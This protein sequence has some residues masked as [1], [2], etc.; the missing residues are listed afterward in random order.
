MDEVIW[1]AIIQNDAAYND[2]FFYGVKSTGIFCRPSCRSRNPK[3]ENVVI[4][5]NAGEALK[6]NF[7]PCKRCKP[8]GQRLPDY[9]WA[10]VIAEYINKNLNNKL[11][12]E[13]LADIVHGSPYH[14]HRTFKKIKGIT[15]VEY[16]QQVRIHKAKEYLQDSEYSIGDIA[17]NVG[18]PNVSYFI[19]LFK[20]KT[21]FT[22]FVY[23]QQKLLEVKSI[24]H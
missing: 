14:S 9:E 7:R 11:T 3:R 23:R 19:T 2:K 21:G 24:G 17:K 12:L 18:I 10:D 1:Q 16:I 6:G 20:K 13:M 15:P 22:P 8:T 4:F 5:Q